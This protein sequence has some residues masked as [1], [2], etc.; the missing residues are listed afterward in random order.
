[1]G[2]LEYPMPQ[3]RQV[4]PA[5]EIDSILSEMDTTTMPKQVGPSDEINNILSEMPGEAQPQ[6]SFFESDLYE[7]LLGGLVVMNV[8]SMAVELEYEGYYTGYY[9]QFERMAQPPN[10]IWS[11]AAES[12]FFWLNFSFSILFLLDIIL[13]IAFLRWNFFRSVANWIDFSVVAFAMLEL[14]DLSELQLNATVLRLLRLIKVARAM[15][16]IRLTK[17]LESLYWMLKCVKASLDVLL[18]AMCLLGM[19]QCIAGMVISQLVRPYLIDESIDPEL[20]RQVFRYYGTFTKTIFTMSEI[21]FANW[22]SPARVLV[23]NISD[24][25]IVVIIIYRCIIGFAILNVVNAV[26]VQQTMKVAQSDHDFQL[27]QKQKQADAYCGKLREFFRTLDTSGD[28]LV[29]WEEFKVLLADPKLQAWMATLELEA[30]DMVH[31]FKMIDDGDGEIS[32][33]EFMDGAMR[34]RGLAKSI[35]VAQTLACSHRIDVKVDAVLGGVAKM[36]GEDPRTLHKT[37]MAQRR[38]SVQMLNGISQFNMKSS[39]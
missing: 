24:T 4:T 15:R 25:W 7:A 35:D 26:F 31:L 28:G 13:R 9:L 12:I 17:I 22:A 11:P 3:A 10:E 39:T 21:M 8:V 33:D 27:V 30:Y 14:I 2:S 29:D 32:I 16:V 18:W 1:M 6:G 38:A 37:A 19:I 5:E 23:D 34:L 20:R 36:V